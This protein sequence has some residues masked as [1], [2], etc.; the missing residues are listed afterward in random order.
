MDLIRNHSLMESFFKHWQPQL[1]KDLDRYRNHCY[2]VVNHCNQLIDLDRE[3]LEQV[4]IAACYHD[5][6]IW[7]DN[8]FDYLKPSQ[9][10]ANNF[11]VRE[12]KSQWSHVVCGMIL[13]HHK[14]T[15]YDGKNGILIEAFRQAD[16]IDV[17]MGVV[18]FSLPRP[19]IRR[20]REAFPYLGFHKML[21]QLTARNLVTHPLK[22][23]PMFKV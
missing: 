17:T 15:P 12:G 13:E 7:L 4:M 9:Y 14:I 8:T 23:L 6:G 16:W 5:V 22:P 19:K 21:A 2:R 10:R 3:Q 1:G 11:L 18:N 20:I